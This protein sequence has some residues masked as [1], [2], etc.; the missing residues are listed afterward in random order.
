MSD[1]KREQ[2]RLLD[3]YCGYTRASEAC[4]ELAEKYGSLGEVYE[5]NE[6]EI[7]GLVDDDAGEYRVAYEA[8]EHLDLAHQASAE[9]HHYMFRCSAPGSELEQ[10]D[11]AVRL[12][13]RTGQLD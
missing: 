5:V 6:P 11:P 2:Q 7:R 10:R 13:G 3:L 9:V 8:L 1:G 4:F 12:T